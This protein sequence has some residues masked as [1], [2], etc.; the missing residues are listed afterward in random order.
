MKRKKTFE[1]KYIDLEEQN[2]KI[3]VS[4]VL[5]NQNKFNDQFR[6]QLRE[7]Y[8]R[9]KYGSE[10]KNVWYQDTNCIEIIEKFIKEYLT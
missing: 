10:F 9:I 7:G 3:V 5:E 2:N 1:E 8:F 6:I 4:L